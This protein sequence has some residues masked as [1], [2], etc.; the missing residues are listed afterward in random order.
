[1]IVRIQE[2]V[3]PLYTSKSDRGALFFISNSYCVRDKSGVLTSG[4]IHVEDCQPRYNFTLI[5]GIPPRQTTTYSQLSTQC[6]LYSTQGPE[7]PLYFEEINSV[8]IYSTL[9]MLLWTDI[10]DVL[11]FIS[12]SRVRFPMVSEFFIDIILLAAL[13]P[14]SSLIL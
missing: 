4:N 2:L 6:Q 5:M 10:R 7:C 8:L 14:W 12:R 3:H 9:F 13:W 11:F 1:M